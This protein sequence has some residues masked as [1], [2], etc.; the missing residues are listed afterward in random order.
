MK[1]LDDFLTLTCTPDLLA[2]KLFPNAKEVTESQAMYWLVCDELAKRGVNRKDKDVVIIETGCGHK[3]RT[4]ALFA[5][6]SAWT[7]IAIDPVVDV[8]NYGDR[9][10]LCKMKDQR[11]VGEDIEK[12]TPFRVAVV[13]S[14]HGHG[15]PK[16]LYDRLTQDRKA[17]FEMPCCKPAS[18]Q[19]G[20]FKIDNGILSPK[21]TIYWKFGPTWPMPAVAK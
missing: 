9:V 14:V 15:Q 10:L 21:R 13:V 1:Y 5:Y 11:F 17:I 20:R 19:R 3:P 8:G 16:A 6:R 7:C 12:I 2:L 18:L 4:S